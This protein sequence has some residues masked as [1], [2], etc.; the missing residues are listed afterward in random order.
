MTWEI[1][2][3]YDIVADWVLKYLKLGQYAG[4]SECKSVETLFENMKNSSSMDQGLVMLT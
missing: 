4:L 1:K 3:L 2:K